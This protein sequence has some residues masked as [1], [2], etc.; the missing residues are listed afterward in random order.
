MKFISTLLLTLILML[1]VT[2]SWAAQVPTIQE[3]YAAAKSGHLDQAQRMMEQVLAAHPDSAKA[4]FV[5]AEILAAAHRY[6]QARSELNKAQ[7]LEPGLPFE[8]AQT[9][10]ALQA[11]IAQGLHGQAGGTGIP[12]MLI[13]LGVA[14]LILLVVVA[15]ALLTP[16]PLPMNYNGGLPPNN[17]SGTVGGAPV[18]PS[19]PLGG[20]GL[21]SGLTTGLGLG[22]GIAA[23]EALVNH[24]THQSSSSVNPLVS[25]QLAPLDDQVASNDLGGN[26]FGMN[27]TSSWD[28]TSVGGDFSGSDSGGG[29]GWS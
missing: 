28:D 2:T 9:V 3:V 21:M 5:E 7:Q 12:W 17:M 20:G 6:A 8:S 19:S 11:R 29:D 4:H 23:G 25:D 10:Q 13:L 22:A 16:K 15:R 24:F 26:D 14:G 27:D 1:G 18:F